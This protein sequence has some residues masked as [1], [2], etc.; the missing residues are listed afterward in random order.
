MT[1]E[2]PKRNADL[3]TE[4]AAERAEL[5][6]LR[7]ELAEERQLLDEE[8]AQFEKTQRGEPR[9]SSQGERIHQRDL[10]SDVQSVRA[11]LKAHGKSAV[12]RDYEVTLRSGGGSPR[13]VSPVIAVDEAEAISIA[14]ASL[15]IESTQAYNPHVR[16]ID[17]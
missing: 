1:E 3:A 12:V 7:A 8:L 16:A 2:K 14:F 4:L 15:K 11:W 17:P 13:V 9:Q 10:P 6:K 5:T